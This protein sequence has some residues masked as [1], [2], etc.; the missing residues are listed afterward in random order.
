MRLSVGSRN[1]LSF[2]EHRHQA[3]M[4]AVQGS[5]DLVNARHDDLRSDVDADLTAMGESVA[6]KTG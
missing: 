6:A 2:P 3:R 4:D 1:I 5:V